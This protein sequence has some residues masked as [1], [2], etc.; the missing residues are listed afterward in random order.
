MFQ[1]F[2]SDKRT[3]VGCAISPNANYN[4]IIWTSHGFR[5]LE[6]KIGNK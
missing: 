3:D 1:V 4:D 2:Q 6:I 5:M